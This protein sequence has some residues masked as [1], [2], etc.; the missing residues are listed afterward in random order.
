MDV[1]RWT[2][3]VGCSEPLESVHIHDEDDCSADEDLH[4]ARHEYADR[5][6]VRRDEVGILIAGLA[7]FLDD[8]QHLIHALVFNA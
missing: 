3:D 2:L 1:E 7:A 5:A 4:G 8:V 6:G